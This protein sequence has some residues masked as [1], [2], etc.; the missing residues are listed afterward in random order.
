MGTGIIK[1]KA[2]R[3]DF[4][5]TGYLINSNR[6]KM[7]LIY[8]IKLQKWLPPGG[9][10]DNNELPHECVI[11][12]VIEE[13]GIKATIID[14]GQKF[15]FISDTEKQLPTPYCI[16]HELIPAHKNDVEHMHVDFIYLMQ[17]RQSK[18][19]LKLNEISQAKWLDKQS[20]INI[21]TYPMVKIIASKILI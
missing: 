6:T 13:T 9:H 1:S 4:T 19:K 3:N 14:K 11:R 21:N 7:L 10:W 15:G 20:I 16:L 2:L 12:E 5:S 18:I 8:H 17:T